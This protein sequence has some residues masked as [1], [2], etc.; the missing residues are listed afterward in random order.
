MNAPANQAVSDRSRLVAFLFCFFLGYL[1]IHRFYVGKSGTGVAMLLTAGG[2]GVWWLV[3]TILLLAGG[4]SDKQGGAVS[5]WSVS[6]GASTHAAAEARAAR[7]AQ[8]ELSKAAMAEAIR[9]DPSLTANDD[10]ATL[11][12]LV[13][14]SQQIEQELRAKEVR[15]RVQADQEQAARTAQEAAAEQQEREKAAALRQA[16]WDA[17]P[18]WRRVVVTKPIPLAVGAVAFVIAGVAA[19]AVIQ[20]A[21]QQRQAE[22]A[23]QEEAAQIE[24][25]R[26]EARAEEIAAL[27]AEREAAEAE[28]AR[29]SA[30]TD[31]C[32]TD[33]VP[34]VSDV[35]TLVSLSGCEEEATVVAV[36]RHP[37]VP[38][39]VAQDMLANPSGTIRAEALRRLDLRWYS[40]DSAGVKR[41]VAYAM[42]DDPEP[43][44]RSV[45][46]AKLSMVKQGDRPTLLKLAKD[47]DQTVVT[48]VI[49]N[50]PVTS[51]SDKS[52]VRILRVAC[53]QPHNETPRTLAICDAVP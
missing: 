53:A 15:A 52:E 35:T 36:L 24:A 18:R 21:S 22:L 19:V 47:A 46:A 43:K 17:M 23:A 51:R 27:Q 48:S 38:Q 37:S 44:V 2:L 29:L 30:I 7:Q 25:D 13:A 12:R 39:S 20:D 5:D 3:D 14:A 45:L 32:D 31:N 50:N 26:R 10:P 8:E 1:G 49:Q 33:L 4:F 42:V 9:R 28:A 11:A 6:G 16:K 34:L 40:H 41:S